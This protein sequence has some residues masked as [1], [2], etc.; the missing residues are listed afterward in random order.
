MFSRAS[1]SF[2]I[3]L[4]LLAMFAFHAVPAFSAAGNPEEVPM[5]DAI[6]ALVIAPEKFR[7]EELFVPKAAFEKAGY[8]TIVA[9]TR[10][11][12]ATGML[13]GFAIATTGITD[14]AP[15]GIAALVIVG[16]SGSPAHLWGNPELHSLAVKMAAAGKPVAAICVSPAVLARAGVLKG[17]K[18]TVFTDN[19]S[20]A[21]LN[22]HG[23]IYEAKPCVVDGNIV[24][25][26]GPEAA[27]EFAKAI[28]HLLQ[29]APR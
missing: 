29:T 4:F 28:L 11:G 12:T 20:I 3:R 6:I 17:R 21:E 9:S 15:A 16:G 7:D 23:A 2:L 27:A 22:K 14:L 18:A 5:S 13:G 25:A 19:A 26:N 1:V 10:V 24:T 8:Q